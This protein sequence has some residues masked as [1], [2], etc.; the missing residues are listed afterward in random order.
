MFWTFE[1]S[2]FGF[3]SACPGATC[4][5]DFGAHVVQVWARDFGFRYS[6][7]LYV[8]ALIYGNVKLPKSCI[9]LLRHCTSVLVG[10]RK[11]DWQDTSYVLSYFGKRIGDARRRYLSYVEAGID[12]GRRPDLVGGGL[13]RSLGGWVEARKQRSRGQDRARGTILKAL[14]KESVRYTI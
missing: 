6:D 10:K 8:V 13:I 11:C 5:D 4:P 14:S 3:V 9:E 12:E 2:D 7:F 1:H